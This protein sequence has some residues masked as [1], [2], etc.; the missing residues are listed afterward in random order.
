MLKKRPKL[1]VSSLD[2]ARLEALL[3]TLSGEGF[4]GKEELEEELVRADIVA[5]EEMPHDVVTMNSTVVFTTS[6]GGKVFQLTLVY[7]GDAAKSDDNISILA[8]VGG[9]LLGLAVGDAI[10]WPLP[11]GRTVTVRIKDIL[12]QPERAGEYEV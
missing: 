9:A 7:P 4:P 1:V 2:A 11:G 12:Y 5:P 6:P 10:E 3:E 8:P